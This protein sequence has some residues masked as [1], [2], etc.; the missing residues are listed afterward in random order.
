MIWKR[1]DALRV[2]SEHARNGDRKLFA[3]YFRMYSWAIMV[4]SHGFRCA[5]KLHSQ[6]RPSNPWAHGQSWRAPKRYYLVTRPHP[7]F[8]CRAYQTVRDKLEF[9]VADEDNNYSPLS[10]HMRANGVRWVI[11]PIFSLYLS[12]LH[13]SSWLYRLLEQHRE[14]SLSCCALLAVAWALPPIFSL[15]TKFVRKGIGLYCSLDWNDPAVH[16]RIFLMFLISFN[17]F[18]PFIFIDANGKSTSIV[19][20]NEKKHLIWELSSSIEAAKRLLMISILTSAA[21]TELQT[22]GEN[23]L[24]NYDVPASFF[25]LPS[26]IICSSSS[27]IN[28]VAS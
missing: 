1:F 22:V 18:I 10:D 20:E 16:S 13:K 24:S 9:L 28:V 23:Q 8:L 19:C 7:F 14:A 17:Y 5:N 26:V 27:Q 6:S 25:V 15:G 21:E 12:V 11:L 3:Q 4:H 2:R